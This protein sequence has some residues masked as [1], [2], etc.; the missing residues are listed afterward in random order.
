[1]GRPRG[2]AARVGESDALFPLTPG[3]RESVSPRSAEST[4]SGLLDALAGFPPLPEGE[5]RGEGEGTVELSTSSSRNKN[6]GDAST[7]TMAWPIPDSKVLPFC[8]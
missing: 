2:R 6:L 7:A 1:M 4:R 3:E 5:G 8:E